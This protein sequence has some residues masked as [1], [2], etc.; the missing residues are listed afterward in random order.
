M[1]FNNWPF[2]LSSFDLNILKY[3]IIFLGLLFL[4]IFPIKYNSKGDL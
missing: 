1:S 3:P 2:R 4:A